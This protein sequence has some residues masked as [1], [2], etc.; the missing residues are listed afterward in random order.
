[1]A[2]RQPLQAEGR[3]LLAPFPS[4]P[5]IDTERSCSPASTHILLVL[6]PGMAPNSVGATE[7]TG[8]I[9]I[10]MM[11]VA[12]TCIDIPARVP[13]ASHNHVLRPAL[14]YCV[15]VGEEGEVVKGPFH[16]M[17]RVVSESGMR[18]PS[19]PVPP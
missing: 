13:C 15:F 7:L 4:L 12:R 14:F 17:R 5:L 6:T 16:A 1:M 10:E 3:P 2:R 9:T 19:P 18:R 8:N 11:N